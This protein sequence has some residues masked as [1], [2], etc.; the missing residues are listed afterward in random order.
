M[1]YA[2]YDF[3]TMLQVS[4]RNL[5]IVMRQKNKTGSNEERMRNIEQ[6]LSKA[7][8]AVNLDPS[9]GVS[10]SVL[11]N[12]HL[13]HFFSVSQNPRTLKQAMTAYK[14]AEKDPIAASSSDLHYNKGVALRFEE[15]Y[16][17]ALEAFTRATELDPAWSKPKEQKN[18][19]LK[20][21]KN[22]V[23]LIELK[24]KLKVKK[25]NSLVDS[26][27]SG[28]EQSLLGPYGGGAFKSVSLNQT[29]FADLQEG[30]NSE[31][32]VVGKVI[33]SVHTADEVPFTFCL[34]DSDD[35]C[36]AVNLYNLS[37]GKGVIIGDAVAIAERYYTQVKVE[38]FEFG[39]IR[40]DSPLVLVINGKKAAQD[41]QAGI[42]LST[43][44]K[45]P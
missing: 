36:L 29:T 3:I 15:D 6:G 17:S 19:M 13:M 28:S 9:D 45:S 33:C 42:Q 4:L 10:W 25:F 22:V 44:T 14:Q 32:V 41:L 20:T 40:V 24:G 16:S 31:K 18:E 5:S 43:F 21:L 30:L 8:E 12:A 39:L 27:K 23:T 26:L 34:T 35:K 37:P 1:L 11:G 2:L 7:R 38:E